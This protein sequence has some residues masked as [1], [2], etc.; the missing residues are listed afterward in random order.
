MGDLYI[1]STPIGNLDDITLRALKTLREV[2]Y[3]AAEDTRK[4]GILL[5]HHEI[6]AKLLSYHSHSSD[7]KVE[8]IVE[9]LA[10][11]EDVAV[12]SDAGTPGISDPAYN[13]IQRAIEVGV[14]IIPIP[15]A[16][17]LLAALTMSGLPMNKFL[18]VGFLPLKKGRQTMLEKL[19]ASEQTLVIFES[20]HRLNKTLSQLLEFFGDRDF[21]VGREITKIYEEALRMKISEAIAHFESKKPKGEFVLVVSGTGR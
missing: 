4:T 2:A 21:A 13:L 9:I 3:V 5:K 11:G 6:D 20:P 10:G 15:G 17:S 16:S 1:V 7:H 14:R 8:K 12:V 18:Y 19:A